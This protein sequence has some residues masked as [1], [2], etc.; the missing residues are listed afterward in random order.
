[1][2]GVFVNTGVLKP[3]PVCLDPPQ[4]EQ[5]G[6]FGTLFST[7][8]SFPSAWPCVSMFTQGTNM[9]SVSHVSPAHNTEPRQL[10]FSTVQL[11]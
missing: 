1:M 8:I 7:Q 5:I 4:K 3:P 2:F 11:R 9:L 10:T 6:L